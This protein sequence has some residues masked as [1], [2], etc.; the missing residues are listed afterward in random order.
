MIRYFLPVALLLSYSSLPCSAQILYR[1][2]DPIQLDES[3]PPSF[4]NPGMVI[5][6]TENIRLASGIQLDELNLAGAVLAEIDS[7]SFQS[8]LLNYAFLN[9]LPRANFANAKIN[10]ARLANSF[11]DSNFSGA[12]LES[13]WFATNTNSRQ[14][15]FSNANLQN[16]I[17]NGTF[18]DARFDNAT[19]ASAQLSGRY[20]RASFEDANLIGNSSQSANFLGEFIRANFTNVDFGKSTMD[21]KFMEANFSGADLTQVRFGRHFR[22]PSPFLRADLSGA[23]FSGNRIDDVLFT[24]TVFRE[25]NFTGTYL[26]NVHFTGVDLRG[27]NLDRTRFKGGSLIL[28]DLRQVDLSTISGGISAFT[29]SRYDQFTIFPSSDF[30]PLGH[31]M[32]FVPVIPGDIDLD[33]QVNFEDFLSFAAKFGIACDDVDLACWRAGDFN[34]DGNVDFADFLAQS[35]NFGAA[36]PAHSVPEPAP[37]SFLWIVVIGISRFLLRREKQK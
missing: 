20:L 23:N 22:Q 21:G 5:P 35:A 8:T 27:A 1:S 25:A 19:L 11:E 15:N 29:G 2:G 9:D 33:D 6:G 14:A 18:D 17:L 31:G 28:S 7:A 26:D 10:E 30:D 4:S 36:A 34:L 37:P 32:E 12:S 24:D 3:D 16:A 13:S